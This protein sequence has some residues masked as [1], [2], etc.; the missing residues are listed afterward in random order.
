MKT[1]TLIFLLCSGAGFSVPAL[2]A[3][4]AF[5]LGIKGGK[6]VVDLPEYN[7]NSSTGLVLGYK[8]S[9]GSSGSVAVEGEFTESSKA[10]IT[11]LKLT[12]KWDIQTQAIYLATRI[13]GDL[14]FKAK[15]GYLNEDVNVDI[16]GANIAGSDSGLSAGLGLGWKLGKKAFIELEFTIIEQD[17]GFGSFGAHFSF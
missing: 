5:Y 14:Y 2:A 11:V 3:D 7:D 16:V 9:D 6:M 4:N 12:G 13:G 17:I 10:D 1:K 8:I 15:V